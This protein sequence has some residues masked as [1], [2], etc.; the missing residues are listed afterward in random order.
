L[1]EAAMGQRAI[2]QGLVPDPE[3]PKNALIKPRIIRSGG[4]TPPGDPNAVNYLLEI[5]NDPPP[6][7]TRDLRVHLPDV[8]LDGKP[9]DDFFPVADAI[10]WSV[11]AIE[12]FLLPY[13]AS[14]VDLRDI[15]EK[16]VQAFNEKENLL[17]LI[18]LPN[19]EIEDG[20]DGIASLKLAGIYH[21]A[22]TKQLNIVPLT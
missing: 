10:F 7:K 9:V 19:S 6:H 13:Y 17:A 1:A 3:N 11:P 12:K 8:L 20:V 15:H 4:A 16:I 2:P 21:D 22:D 14:F 5:D 18:H